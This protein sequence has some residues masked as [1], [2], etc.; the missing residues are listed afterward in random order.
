M[1]YDSA[2]TYVAV[3][4]INQLAGGAVLPHCFHAVVNLGVAD[5]LRDDPQ[6]AASLAAS[7]G[8]SADALGRA[9]RLLATHG[10]FEFRDGQFSH[11]S[12]SLL[13]RAD[14][15]QSMRPLYA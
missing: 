1:E 7:I 12:A 13:L 3:E 10:V 2:S 5:A 14:H 6:T 8:L 4:K 11:T 15:S 9:L